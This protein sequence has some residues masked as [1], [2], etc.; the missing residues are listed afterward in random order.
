M[1]PN[2]TYKFLH[3]D[4]NHQQ[5]KKTACGLGENICRQCDLQGLTSKVHKE[6]IQLNIKKKQQQQQKKLTNNPIKNGQKT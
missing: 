5:K 6:L 2:K 3:S 1:E 4:G